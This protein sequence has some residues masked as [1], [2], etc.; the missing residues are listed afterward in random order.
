MHALI[1]I[2]ISYS[3]NIFE[4]HQTITLT[5]PASFS[6][7][8]R[9][10]NVALLHFVILCFEEMQREAYACL[11]VKSLKN[12]AADPLFSVKPVLG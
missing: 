5:T 4:H 2:S 3:L 8:G 6:P 1:S 10:G 7:S 11:L 12:L 9:P